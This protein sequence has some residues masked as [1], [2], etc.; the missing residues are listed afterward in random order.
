MQLVLRHRDRLLAVGF[1]IAVVLAWQAA[2][3][4]VGWRPWLFPAPSHIVEA[5]GYL[6]TSSVNVTLF[7]A[8]G[9]SLVRLVLGFALAIALAVPIG[10]A[11]ARSPLV[12]KIFGGVFLGVQTIP[13]V[14]WAPLAVLTFGLNEAS[15]LFVLVMGSAFGIAV[16][17]RDGVRAVSPRYAQIGRM[18][19][20]RRLALYR[21]VL[22]PASLPAFVSSLRQGFSFAWRSLLGAE[23]VIMLKQ[24]GL[25]YLLHEGREFADLGQVLAVMATMIVVGIAVDRL[26]FAPAER[27]IHGRFG[28]TAAS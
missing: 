28:L 7:G 15:I 1:W 3:A 25:G 21:R 24:K 9:A 8:L 20:A 23:L 16:S 17:F 4:L 12:D 13:S 10:F 6:V 22:F 14:C 27:R 18:F 26:L 2:Y 19:G 11:M 5:L